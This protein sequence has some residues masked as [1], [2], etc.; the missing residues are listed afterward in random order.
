MPN[1]GLGGLI[2]IFWAE[3]KQPRS[4]WISKV[5]QMDLTPILFFKIRGCPGSSPFSSPLKPWVAWF[6]HG[7][8]VIWKNRGGFGT[9]R[10]WFGWSLYS[11]DPSRLLYRH[12][13]TDRGLIFREDSRV[14]QIL[15]VNQTLPNKCKN[16][17]PNL[18]LTCVYYPSNRF[19]CKQKVQYT[20]TSARGRDDVMGICLEK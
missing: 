11:T 17:F 12:K 4:W 19:V 15:V 9:R 13:R 1:W 16:N 5:K 14:L 2:Q 10:E 18:E 7:R 6:S 20:W 8:L 3:W